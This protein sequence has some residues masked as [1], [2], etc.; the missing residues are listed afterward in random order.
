MIL[1][2]SWLYNEN[3]RGCAPQVQGRE[4]INQIFFDEAYKETQ[5]K[6]NDLKNVIICKKNS[7]EASKLFND[8]YFD[9]IYI[10]AE[11]SYEAVKQD[12]KF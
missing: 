2:D 5:K 12:L 1:I 3:I 6:F 11:H 9:Y 8:N 4:P 10:D 7:E